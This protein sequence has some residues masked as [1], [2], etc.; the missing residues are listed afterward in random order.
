MMARLLIIAIW[1]P[2]P[3]E[4]EVQVSKRINTAWAECAGWRFGSS[5]ESCNDEEIAVV[6][7]G[8]KFHDET[9]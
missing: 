2:L 6:D 4:P 5:G 7:G 3:T 1:M 8:T 9:Q